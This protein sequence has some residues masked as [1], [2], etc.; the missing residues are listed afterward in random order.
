MNRL[1]AALVL[2]AAVFLC[3]VPAR[4]ETPVGS[5]VE[6]RLLVGFKVD[7]AAALAWMPEGWKAIT[8]PKGPL[9]GANVMLVLMDRQLILD[10]DGKPQTPSSG[11]AAAL[12]SYGVAEGQPGPRMFITRVFE[13]APM[14]D[15]Y[16]NSAPAQITRA[17]QSAVGADGAT[18]RSE[19]W[20]VTPEAGG[21]IA[22][23]LS[24]TSGAGNLVRGAEALP[25]SAAK[26]EFHR[27][28][29]Y[30]QMVEL[31]MSAALGK[32]V[33]GDKEVSADLP[34]MAGMFDGS[35]QVAAI[36]FIPVYIRDTFLP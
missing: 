6:S 24:F 2:L 31:V 18:T 34:D 17:S 27:I 12:L 10:P 20:V 22:V 25:H 21:K 32:P 5:T 13:P 30:D 16:S 14:V 35:Q 36:L 23:D 3:A 29:R 15:P 28:Y 33:A 11:R 9:A 4:A 7:D 1:P 8:L 19:S 26:P